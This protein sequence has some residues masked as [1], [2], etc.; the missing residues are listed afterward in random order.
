MKIRLF[1]HYVPTIL[2][3][4]AL[5]ECAILFFGSDLAWRWRLH[6]IGKHVPPMQERLG[7]LITYTVVVYLMMLAVGMYDLLTYRSIR[8]SGVRLIAAMGL[9]LVALPIVFYVFPDVTT[10]RSVFLYALGINLTGILIARAIVGQL[11]SWESFRRRI[12]VLG[13]GARAHRIAELQR[14]KRH[15]GFRT[16]KFVQMSDQE[17]AVEGAVPRARVLNLGDFIEAEGAEEI[18]LALD[19]RRGSLPVS[20]LLEAKMRGA[21][22]VDI[23]TFLERETGKVDL[24]TL[25]PSFLIFSDGFLGGRLWSGIFKRTFD[26]VSS[27]LLLILTAPILLVTAIL[28]K[29]TSPGPVFYRQER[30]G[31]F[32][33][34]FEVLKFRSMRTDAEVDGKPQWATQ[35]D[36]RVT[37]VGRVIRL[38]RIDEIPQAINV[39]KGEM[40]FVGPRPERPFF[41]NQLAAKIPYYSERHVMKP[42]LTGWAQISFP[43]GASADDARQKL[44]Y[45]LYY[46][47][48]YTL[49]LDFLILVQ[50]VRVILWQDG[51]R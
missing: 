51:A 24:D 30:V 45:D 39:L 50:T 48:N 20:E 37:A 47:K 23:S 34:P 5:L 36:P 4:L 28:I 12:V 49:F 16:L 46:V 8:Q 35:G 44:E 38:T 1:K 10:W 27:L 25:N 29:L 33:R 18:V 14:T 40:S 11:I 15:P 32:G 21:D 6:D 26:V 3:G 2:I 42:G 17:T 41:V 31:Q 9:A 13:A 43:Y 22:V 7:E 19:E